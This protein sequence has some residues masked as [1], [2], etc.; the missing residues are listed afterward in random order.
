MS[1]HMLT[2]IDNPYDPFKNFDDW[3]QFDEE[4]GYHSC[5]Y[6]ARI[7][8]TS[9]QFSDQENDAEIEA[10]IEEI[11]K[12]DPFGIYLKVSEKEENNKK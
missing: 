11:I 7:A 12:N 6:L 4:K 8:K 10:A 9:N 1:F 2:T 3:F 5:S